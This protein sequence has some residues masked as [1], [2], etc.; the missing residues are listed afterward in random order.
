MLDQ[1][2]RLGELSTGDC[3]MSAAFALSYRDLPEPQQRLFRLLGLHQG[4]DLDRR[5]A[6]VLTG[7]DLASAE[8]AL[9]GLVDVH[10]LE[11][12]GPDRYRLHELLR[13]H[14]RHIA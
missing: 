11:S 1:Q 7:L 10:L 4:P 14:A 3:T 13:E 5:L 2:R 9:E 6:A 8:A 12:T